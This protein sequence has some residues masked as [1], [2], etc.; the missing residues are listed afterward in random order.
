[1]VSIPSFLLP[2]TSLHRHKIVQ[3][4]TVKE[5]ILCQKST[6]K[7]FTSPEVHHQEVTF[8]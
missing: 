5:T 8:P 2:S 1:M 3:K 7:E 4:S 6:V